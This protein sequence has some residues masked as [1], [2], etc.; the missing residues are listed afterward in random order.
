MT[1]LSNSRH[2]IIGK[3]RKKALIYTYVGSGGHIDISLRAMNEGALTSFI[4]RA[5]PKHS[6]PQ[7]IE[8][9]YG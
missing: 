3:K 5:L 8:S 7:R 1:E 9:H 6:L 2:G 4:L